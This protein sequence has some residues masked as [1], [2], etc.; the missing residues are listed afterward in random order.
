VITF[1]A[2][3]HPIPGDEIMGFLSAGKGVVVHQ[4]SCPNVPEFRRNPERWVA[5]DWD[6]NVQG[7]F[8]CALKIVVDNKPGVLATVAAAIAEAGSNIENVEYQERDLQSAA[9]LFT[10]EVR[11]RK[12]LAEVMRRV[13]RSSVV[14]AVARVTG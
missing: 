1:G 10:L 4:V 11:G 12:H 13:R 2:C 8:R 5:I 6:R 9:L 3:C 7:D 14:H